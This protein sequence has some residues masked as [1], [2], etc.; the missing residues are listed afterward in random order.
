[1]GLG[2]LLAHKIADHR[3]TITISTLAMGLLLAGMGVVESLPVLLALLTLYEVVLGIRA[4]ALTTFLNE[5]IPSRIR[6]TTI[7]ALSTLTSIFTITANIAIGLF[8]DALGLKTAY[9]LAGTLTIVA[10]FP[11]VLATDN[12]TRSGLSRAHS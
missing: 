5:L 4:P 1:M 12:M 11:I 2:G 8:A 6:S 3:R 9:L 10:T 7:S